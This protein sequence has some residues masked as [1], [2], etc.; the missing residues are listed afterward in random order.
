MPA[1]VGTDAGSCAAHPVVPAVCPRVLPGVTDDA[2]EWLTVPDPLPAPR[3]PSRPHASPSPP[4]PF[5]PPPAASRAVARGAARARA[6]VA[7]VS[8]ARPGAGRTPTRPARGFSM[9]EVLVS[10]FIVSMGVLAVAGLIQAAARYGKTSELRT[11]ATLLA[12]DIADRIRANPAGAG[13]YEFVSSAWPVAPAAPGAPCNRAAPCTPGALAQADLA[14]W[15]SRVRALLP[16][17]SAYVKYRPATGAAGPA[18]DVWVGWRDGGTLPAVASTGRTG[19]ECPQAWSAASAS[20]RC[21]YLQV[22]L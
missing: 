7:R 14:G 5:L 15:T 18:M 20:V 8:G 11:T 6:R 13:G 21:I 19:T 22:G 4:R 2:P 9:I 17:G 16:L 3:G 10:M 1:G 12:N